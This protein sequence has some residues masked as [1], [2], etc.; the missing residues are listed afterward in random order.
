M[1]SSF[2]YDTVLFLISGTIFQPREENLTPQTVVL[3]KPSTAHLV[4]GLR[5]VSQWEINPQNKAISGRSHT[6]SQFPRTKSIQDECFVL[7]QLE[8]L[9]KPIQFLWKEEMINFLGYLT[10]QTPVPSFHWFA[11]AV[12][13]PLRCS[14]SEF[15]CSAELLWRIF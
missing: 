4:H 2:Q 1:F 13:I 8:T 11:N 15:G 10:K 9:C 6:C 14:S 3:D 12:S 5:F 7:A